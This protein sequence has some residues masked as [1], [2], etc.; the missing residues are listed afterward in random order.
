LQVIENTDPSFETI[1]ATAGRL[2]GLL[3]RNEIALDS[4]ERRLV[5]RSLREV[6]ENRN[7][8]ADATDLSRLAWLCMQ[9]NDQSA[10]M[11][12]VKK[13]LELDSENPHCLK[14]LARLSD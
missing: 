9:L 5:I 7:K 13:G 12:W 1:S 8:E 11:K 2:N 14:L 10:A 4:D 3:A 6:L